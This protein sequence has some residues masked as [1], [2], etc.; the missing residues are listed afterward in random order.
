M[1]LCWAVLPQRSRNSFTLFGNVFAKELEQS[2]GNNNNIITCQYANE[3]RLI[4]RNTE[5]FKKEKKFCS[6]VDNS[7]L[8]GTG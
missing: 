7:V 6:L 1:Q 8:G 2:L 3:S 5:T 4:G